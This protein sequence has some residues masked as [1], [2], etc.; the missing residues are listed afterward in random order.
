MSLT[1]AAVTPGAGYDYEALY[2][3]LTKRYGAVEPEAL[4][5][6]LCPLQVPLRTLDRTI[7]KVAG[8]SHWRATFTLDVTDENREALQLGRTGKFIPRSHVV[9]NAPWREVAKGRIYAVSDEV[10]EGEVYVGAGA[11]ASLEAAV[12][13]LSDDD[14]LEIDQY[15]AA[16][17]V[18]SALV[19]S[20]LAT[21]LLRDGFV[22]R[23]MPE[24]MARHIGVYANYDFEVERDGVQRK[25]EVK[26]L[27]G[28]DTRY[29]RLIHSTGVGYPTSSCKFATQDIFAVSLFLRS[30]VITD[31]AFARSVPIDERPYG[32]P[33]ATG[34]PEHVNQNPLCEVGDGTWFA[35]IGDVWD[36]P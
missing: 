19:E 17:K 32:L 28:T 31:F 30:G 36:L 11:K 8:Q 2:Q 26:S 5:K 6:V 12:A 13:D 16:A 35:D 1:C 3:T 23:R 34:Y 33:R 25:V 4:V 15:G 18:L 22:V 27:W 24:D 14:F 29:A 21:R 10:A 20:T 9:A 7:V